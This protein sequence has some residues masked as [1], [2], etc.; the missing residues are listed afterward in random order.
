VTKFSCVGYSLGGLVVRYMIGLLEARTPSY[1]DA[2]EP[3]QLM[4]IASPAIGIPAYNTFWSPIFHALGSRLLSRTGRQLYARDR[5]SGKKPLLEVMAD[6]RTSFI[7]ALKRFRKVSIYANA[8]NDRCVCSNFV[9][10]TDEFDRTVPYP[11]AGLSK[12]DPFALAASKAHKAR[13]HRGAADDEPMDLREG[14]LKVYVRCLRVPV[15]LTVD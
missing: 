13:R 8:I 15:R 1:F 14:G 3:V 11:T 9:D 4:T 7:K 2:V 10:A 6:P 5:F 12:T